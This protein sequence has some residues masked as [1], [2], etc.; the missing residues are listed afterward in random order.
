MCLPP[1]TFG[2]FAKLM[3][4]CAI[5]KETL[6]PSGASRTSAPVQLHRKSYSAS[7]AQ[8]QLASGKSR[9]TMPQATCL[10]NTEDL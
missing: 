4:F 9:P 8:T 1:L 6:I 10:F 5:V 3:L 2:E 7:R